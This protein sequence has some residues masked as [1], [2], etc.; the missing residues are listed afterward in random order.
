MLDLSIKS[1]IVRAVIL[2]LVI[3]P[4]IWVPAQISIEAG[5]MLGLIGTSQQ[6]EVNFSENTAID[7]GAAGADQQWDLSQPLSGSEISTQEFILPGETPFEEAFPSANFAYRIT[8]TTD[9]DFGEVEIYQFAKIDESGYANLGGGISSSAS[10]FDTSFVSYRAVDVAPLPLAFGTEWMS[11]ESDTFSVENFSMISVDSATN[12]VDAWGTVTLP[13]GSF[14]CLRIRSDNKHIETTLIGGMVI[15]QNTD[16]TIE[17]T[18]VSKEH[19]IIAVAES[20][21]GIVD[22]DFN[23]AQSFQRVLTAPTTAVSDRPGLARSVNVYPNPFSENINIEINSPLAEPVKLELV[24][25]LGQVINRKELGT[26]PSG[27]TRFSWFI[28][29]GQLHREKIYFLRI[30]ESSRVNTIK[31]SRSF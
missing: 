1:G 23:T 11:F 4:L 10:M 18:W 5:D 8:G 13:G 14:D 30:I 24:N 25:Q 6:V 22:P 27:S 21:D 12:R 31:L 26:S 7:V 3:Y 29:S 19:F 9:P 20:P 2:L 28:N 17:Y 16:N 15:M